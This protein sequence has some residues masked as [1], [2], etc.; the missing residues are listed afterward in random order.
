[1]SSTCP[2][3]GAAGRTRIIAHRGASGYLPEHSAVAKT[4][5][6]G[7]GADFIE[8]DVIATKDGVLVVLHDI[9]LDEVSDVAT[10]YPE[11]RRD[12]G[13]FY[14]IDFSWAELSEL[15]LVE[16]RRPG[17]DE[18]RFPGRFPFDLPMPVTRFEDEIRLISGLNATMGRH[19]GIY[20][21]I[22]DPAWHRQAGID[23]TALFHDALVTN[24]ELISGPVFVQSF[25]RRA[26][27]RLKDEIDTP[28]PLVQLLEREDALALENDAS[29]RGRIAEYAAGVGLP[30]TTLIEPELVDGRVAATTLA[31][32]LAEAGLLIHPYTMRRDVAPDG[33]A[34]Y[35]ATLRFLI[36]ELEVD[37]LFCDH[38]DD[39]LAVR[40]RSAV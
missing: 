25:D 38:P 15:S 36:H 13:Y 26:L 8:Q 39:A 31:G 10:R 2:E 5:A 17:T 34:D 12:D 30:Y 40:E 4:L 3:P 37:A 6:Y 32:R 24:R 23:L 29:A 1:M 9:Y 27:R 11:R 35:F 14:V 22:K 18:L 21:E 19:V 28:F 33:E 20:P 7:L 16:R